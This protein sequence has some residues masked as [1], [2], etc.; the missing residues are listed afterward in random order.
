MIP[1]APPPKGCADTPLSSPG[2]SRPAAADTPSD[3]TERLVMPFVEQ[4]QSSVMRSLAAMPAG[5][6]VAA[7]EQSGCELDF[8]AADHRHS[9]AL[10]ELV[11]C[12][13]LLLLRLRH[14]RAHIR[15]R[16]QSAQP[17]R[18][19]VADVQATHVGDVF[20]QLY[21]SAVPDPARF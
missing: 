17:G 11:Q 16:N 4:H 12:V 1:N 5:R 14:R 7:R 10:Q 20:V 3:K 9:Q 13:D 19:L 6:P 8:L 21:K 2:A 18:C 15:I